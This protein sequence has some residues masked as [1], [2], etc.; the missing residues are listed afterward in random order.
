MHP[1]D[2]QEFY[3]ATQKDVIRENINKDGV[4]YLNFRTL[5]DGEVTY[6]QAKFVK[7]ENSKDHVI[8]GF[9]NVDETTKRELEAL[10][11]AEIASRAKSAFLFNMSHD[12][13]TPM[14]AITGFTTMAK[15]H[16]DDKEKIED[17]LDK[18]ET[19]GTQLLKE[20]SAFGGSR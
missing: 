6:Y 17:Y 12:I 18:I 16:L 7:D 3:K 10:D 4:Y 2:R 9:H 14:N 15:K 1:D 8:A 11:K 5:I 19:A 20:S 13:R